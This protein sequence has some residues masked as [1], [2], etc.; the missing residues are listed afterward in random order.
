MK[1][2]DNIIRSRTTIKISEQELTDRIGG[3][4]FD[5]DADICSVVGFDKVSRTPVV[6]VTVDADFTKIGENIYD[7]KGNFLAYRSE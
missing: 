4:D 7:S 3:A 1:F 5:P 6:L 2:S